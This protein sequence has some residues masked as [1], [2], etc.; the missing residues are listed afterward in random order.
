M[1]RSAEIARFLAEMPL[2]KKLLVA[3][4]PSVWV[5]NEI[6]RRFPGVTL[7]E[8]RRGAAVASELLAADRAVRTR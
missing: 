3:V 4:L 5:G 7:E 2:W 8:Y 1:D 6:A